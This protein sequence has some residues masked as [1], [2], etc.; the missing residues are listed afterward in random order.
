MQIRPTLEA[1]VRHLVLDRLAEHNADDVVRTIRKLPWQQQQHSGGVAALDT[2]GKSVEDIVAK[3]VMASLRADSSRL[4]LVAS[5]VAGLRAYHERVAV[6][7][8]DAVLEKILEHL[9]DD[10]RQA[11]SKRAQKVLGA[12][13]FLGECYNYKLCESSLIF[14]MLYTVINE[15]HAI[16][17]QDRYAAIEPINKILKD[18]AESGV[19]LPEKVKALLPRAPLVLPQEDPGVGG[20][21]Y[22][23]LVECKADP[24]HYVFRIRMVC[25][26]L[27]TCGSYFTRGTLGAKL[28]RYLT[29]FQRY[30][31][32]KTNVPIDTE[33]AIAG[34]LSVHKA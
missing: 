24:T 28:D 30:A 22:H 14:R 20:W 26:L 21:G 8:L 17:L 2:G 29:Y 7:I 10:N 34:T 27:E 5:F 13:R 23:P 31:L 32:S 18:A 4:E 19:A 9:T 11:V 12:M 6:R 33:F 25:V 15:G 3:T 1:F 16:P